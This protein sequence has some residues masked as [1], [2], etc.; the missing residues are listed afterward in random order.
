MLI[1]KIPKDRYNVAIPCDMLKELGL[2][3]GSEIGI[4]L[5]KTNNVIILR[6]PENLSEDNV[7]AENEDIDLNNEENDEILSPKLPDTIF[8]RLEEITQVLTSDNK[9]NKIEVPKVE[10]VNSKEVITLQKKEERCY[11]CN[12]ILKDNE[13][14]KINGH[15]IC[16]NCKKLEV[17]KFLLYMERRKLNAQKE[18]TE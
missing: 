13:Q 9:K 17:Q 6:N 10:T 8:P 18:E 1:K 16:S 7:E 3:K 11:Y 2:D 5:D 12:E 4:E 15:R 14:L